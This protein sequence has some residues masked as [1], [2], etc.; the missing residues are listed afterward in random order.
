MNEIADGLFIKIRGRQCGRVSMEELEGIVKQGGFCKDD[1][2]WNEDL[3][4]WVRAAEAPELK[5]FFYSTA[6][7]AGRHKA[8]I[9]AVASGKGG[10]GKTMLISSLGIALA[11]M[12]DEVILV[13]ADFGGANLHTCL[14]LLEPRFTLFD[15]FSLQKQSLGDIVLSTPVQHLRLISGAC[16][17]L[18]LAN[19]T[20]LQKELFVQDL[21]N[22]PADK[23]LLDLGAGSSID[24]IELFLLADEKI[25]VA[26]P[27]PTS[28]YEAFGFLK[29]CLL[30]E[31]NNALKGFPPVM[32]LF[33][34]EK[35][36]RPEKMQLTMAELMSKVATI[37]AAAAGVFEKVLRAFRPKMILNMVRNKENIKEGM[38]L[39]VATTELLSIDLD[40]LGYVSF[41][42]A[43]DEAVKNTKPFLLF[44]PDAKASQDLSALIRVKLLGKKGVKEFFEKK[45]WQKQIQNY[46][47]EYPQLD[48][49]KDAPICSIN[50]FYWDNCEYQQGGYPCRVRHLEP[51][52]KDKNSTPRL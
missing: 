23:I 32:E 7:R 39:Q 25:L 3:N 37:D 6:D 22:L 4:D 17:S 11:S 51:V 33:I 34:K 36:N 42:P 52:L 50:C 41:D 18:G 13:D 30:R 26:T 9:Y 48:I 5:D 21:K 28:L 24:I 15:Y 38:A 43:V 40:Y 1:L 12:G 46:S 2:V 20:Y 44:A 49:L 45:K 35:I 47:K 27:Q 29:V 10:V 14:G 16:G 19:P 31:L 8:Q